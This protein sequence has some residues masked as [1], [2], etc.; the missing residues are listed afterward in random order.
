MHLPRLALLIALLAPAISLAE[1]PPPDDAQ[2][3][4]TPPIPFPPQPPPPAEPA[5]SKLL[6]QSLRLEITGLLYLFWSVD[7]EAA[8][9]D[10]DPDGANRFDLSRAFVN[11][12]SQIGRSITARVT[13]DIVRVRDDG[14]SLD[15]SL[16]LRLFFAWVRF[17]DVVPGV[18]VVGGLQANPLNAFD[19]SVWQYRVLGTS[20][21]NVM[22]G[23]PTTDLGVGVTGKH[24]DGELEYH[25]LLANG[26]GGFRTEPNKYK[27]GSARLSWAPFG[28]IAKGQPPGLRLSAL[29]NFGIL[30]RTEAVDLGERHLARGQLVGMLSF[31]KPWGTLAAGVGPTWD[32]AATGGRSIQH[33]L[34][35]TGFGFVNLPL[36]LRLLGRFDLFVP[37]LEHS[38]ETSDENP[39]TGVRNRVI[40]GLAYRFDEKVQLIA[41]YQRFG[42]QV[43]ERTRPSD[44]GSNLF[45]HLE[46][47]F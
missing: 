40:A 26:E 24:F 42:W 44:L 16:A 19:D 9:P 4:T 31:E 47:R 30:D 25:L 45:L 11:F 33:G 32:S 22:N 2:E 17:A 27:T 15:G 38:A 13:P 23:V 36:K 6:L 18:S 5:E 41:D 21:F 43:P 39:T 1:T 28:P 35:A 37:D 7:L 34:L 8:N 3:S 12:E 29:A 10:V 14:S 20:I 46:A